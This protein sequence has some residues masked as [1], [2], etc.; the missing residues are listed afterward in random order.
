MP[1]RKSKPAAKPGRP[2]GA[3][4]KG[5][6][7]GMSPDAL[8]L[9]VTEHKAINDACRKLDGFEPG[10]QGAQD[11]ETLGRLWSQHSRLEA[12]VIYPAFARAGV[13]EAMIAEAE[14][15][16]DLVAILMADL[17]ERPA[18]DPH[19]APGVKVLMRLISQVIEGKKQKKG[20]LF[21]A[22]KQASVD[23]AELGSRLKEAIP[24]QEGETSQPIELDVR[25]IRPVAFSQSHRRRDEASR[26]SYGRAPDRR[27]FARSEEQR[28]GLS[29]R[30][31]DPER[32]QDF[33]QRGRVEDQY[34]R[35]SPE[36]DD[37]YDDDR[38]ETYRSS[39]YDDDR[40]ERGRDSRGYRGGRQDMPRDS[41]EERHREMDYG[42]E[43]R[44]MRRY[45]SG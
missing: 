32:E 31:D 44:G 25:E 20:G 37:R 15:G 22:A 36:N 12:G 8:Q 2:R 38:R 40:R 9:L 45:R 42:D 1:A 27:P 6:Q 35:R 26:E 4:T 5:T 16:H 43:R 23:I 17:L 18:D 41:D 14:I 28:H 7:K 29:G 21:A 11:L 39:A 24:E 34:Y 3:K 30:G 13:D 19:L 33:R 10:E